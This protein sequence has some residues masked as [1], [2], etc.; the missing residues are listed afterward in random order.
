MAQDRPGLFR[1][2]L[3]APANH[4]RRAE[5]AISL[6]ADAVILDLEDAVAISEKPAARGAALEALSRPRRCGGY[7]RVNALSTEWAYRDLA[8]VVAKQVDGIVLP[9]VESAA[10]LITAD[11]LIGAL[12]REAGLAPR[13]IDLIP[14]IETAAG[15]VALDAIARAGTRVKRLAFG[16][17]DFTLDLNLTWT[18]EET[19]L[20]PYRSAFVAISRAAGLEAPIDTVWTDLRDAEGF[21]ASVE[22]AR[23]LGFQGKLC[24]HPD[25][26]AVANRAFAPPPA[27][28]ERAR[29]VL[30]AF[31]EAE[32]KGLAS[33]TLDGMF[34]DYPIA[35]AARRVIARAD[36][37]AAAEATP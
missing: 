23:G 20:L 2:M 22:R 28:V 35:I 4:A 18:R 16:A 14:I 24:I 13:S 5:K 1:T 33:I 34:I 25:Q 36:A 10:E 27:Q 21:V 31:D 8:S 29:R 26:I 3:F 9:K 7:V 17:G 32:A 37:I 30:A 6:G 12:E 19:E 11:W 15:Y